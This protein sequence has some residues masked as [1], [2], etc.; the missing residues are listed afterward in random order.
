MKGKLKN[1]SRDSFPSDKKSKNLIS[2]WKSQQQDW[3]SHL[4]MNF[5][6]DK[7]KVA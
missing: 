6:G 2:G 5:F 3:T 1:M 4:G 7:D